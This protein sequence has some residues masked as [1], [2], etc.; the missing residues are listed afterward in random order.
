VPMV[1]DRGG[2]TG[3]LTGA[4]AVTGSVT[5][6]GGRGRVTLFDVELGGALGGFGGAAW[7]LRRVRKGIRLFLATF[8]AGGCGGTVDTVETAGLATGVERV[9]NDVDAVAGA[10]GAEC[11][12][13]VETGLSL[14]ALLF[15]V[16]KKGNEEGSCVPLPPRIDT[17]ELGG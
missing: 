5:M 4:A 8:A 12:M 15:R 14:A 1:A 2:K 17:G 9:T 6:R 16:D 3:L 11:A 10:M 13:A 7:L